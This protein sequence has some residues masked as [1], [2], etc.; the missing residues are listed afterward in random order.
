LDHDQAL[1]QAQHG[2]PHWENALPATH[3]QES[4]PRPKVEFGATLSLSTYILDPPNSP[5]A[6]TFLPLP[7]QTITDF[8][9][10]SPGSAA[11]RARLAQVLATV[12]STQHDAKALPGSVAVEDFG[13]PETQ[14][15][16]HP[17]TSSPIELPSTTLPCPKP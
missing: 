9:I 1:L 10:P 13:T 12:K 3:H 17:H 5:F 11:A 6:F 8:L 7:T 2:P 4:V 14:S 15:Q 16:V